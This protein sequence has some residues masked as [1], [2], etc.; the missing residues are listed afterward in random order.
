[1]PQPSSSTNSRS[2]L[3]GVIF[4]IA[5][6]KNAWIAALIFVLLGVA[7]AGVRAYKRYSYPGGTF[8]FSKSGMSDF[9]NGALQPSMAFRDG[10]SPYSPVA[11]EPYSMT[12]SAPPYSPVLFMIYTPLT[13][14]SLHQADIVF[15]T[16]NV[17]LVGLIAYFA[18]SMSHAKFAWTPWLWVLGMFIFSRPGHITLFTGYF[19]AQLVIGTLMACHYAKTR[20]FLAGAGMLLASGKPTYILPLTILM[21]CRRNFKA[22]VIGLVFCIIGG[23]IGVGWLASHSSLQEVIEGVRAGQ[24]A[25]DDDP[26]EFPVNTWTRL[27]TIGMVSKAMA[28][29]PGNHIYLIGMLV[30]MIVPGIAIYRTSRIESNTGA[31]GISAM[32]LCLAMLVTIYHHSYDCLLVTVM[33]VGVTFFGRQV[34]P[35]LKPFERF[36][37]TGLLGIPA[38]NY[39]ATLRVR[40]ALGADNQSV[41]WNVVTSINGVCLLIALL[42]L[43]LA[44]FRMKPHAE[45]IANGEIN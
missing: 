19:T 24:K 26:T 31:T 34:C 25:F 1:M 13:Y 41:V 37:L 44:A 40:E 32:I 36:A 27:D 9:H 16:I 35:E 15:F 10:V 14:L 17:L 12:R 30:M 11:C 7:F 38:L 33:W 39:L 43:V 2:P 28:W 22:V 29:K 3:A 20:P 4:K 23:L 45:P 6:G 42:I 5:F 21:L 18:F 8:D